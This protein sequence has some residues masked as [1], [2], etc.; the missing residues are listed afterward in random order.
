MLNKASFEVVNTFGDYELNSFNE[1]ESKRL[2]IMA[3]KK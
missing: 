1:L 3:I 2:I